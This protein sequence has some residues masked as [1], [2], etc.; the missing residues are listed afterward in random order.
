MAKPF[1]RPRPRVNPLLFQ[2]RTLAAGNISSGSS[3]STADIEV[4]IGTIKT[5]LVA[6][7]SIK[8]LE[9]EE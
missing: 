2:Q 5:R 4:S 8:A 9:F 1:R 6:L 7:E 3:G